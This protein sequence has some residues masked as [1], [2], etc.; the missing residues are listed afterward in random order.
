[1]VFNEILASAH[2]LMTDVFGNYVIQ[3]FFEHGTP[4]QKTALVHKVLKPFLTLGPPG[5]ARD[6]LGPPGT[7]W[8]LQGPPGTFGNLFMGSLGTFFHLIT[9]LPFSAPIQRPG[10]GLANVWLPSDPK[11]LGEYFPGTTETDHNRAGRQCAQVRQG[12]EW[13]PC[14]PEVY[15]DCR[16][17]LPSVHHRCLSRPGMY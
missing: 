9:F 7:S 3:K 4:E 17:C 6:L 8:D 13:Q 16:P 2:S 14:R 1:M 12:P 15:R 11:G 5:S 10:S